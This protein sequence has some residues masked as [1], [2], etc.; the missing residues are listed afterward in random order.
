MITYDLLS[1]YIQELTPQLV[2]NDAQLCYAI[3]WYFAV[4]EAEDGVD[5]GT[6][7]L[8]RY[9]IQGVS[10]FPDLLSKQDVV[11]YIETYFDDDENTR[12]E[13]LSALRSFGFNENMQNHENI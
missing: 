3:R 7:D 4:C 13:W 9:I 6:R 1:E 10:P 8:A 11:D 2:W 5:M 12:E